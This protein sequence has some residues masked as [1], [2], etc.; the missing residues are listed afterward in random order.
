MK[1]LLIIL[2]FLIS[3]ATLFSQNTKVDKVAISVRAFDF[4]VKDLKNCD[5]L[6]IRYKELQFKVDDFSKISLKLLKRNDSLQELEKLHLDKINNLN[7]DV[8]KVKKRPKLSALEII[9]IT[10]SAFALGLAL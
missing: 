9:L 8:L 6:K 2:V 7:K 5:S 3:N 4:I 10:T 1:N